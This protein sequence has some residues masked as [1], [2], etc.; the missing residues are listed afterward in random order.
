MA[1][2]YSFFGETHYPPPM[3]LIACGLFDDARD[4]LPFLRKSFRT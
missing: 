3:G 4:L 1:Q 2:I